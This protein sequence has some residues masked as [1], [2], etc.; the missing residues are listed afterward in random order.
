VVL[1]RIRRG[2]YLSQ[3]HKGTKARSQTKKI[4]V[5]I[6]M[7]SEMRLFQTDGSLSEW[8]KIGTDTF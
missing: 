5:E 4:R 3:R 2:F 8:R 1:G 7:G 6:P